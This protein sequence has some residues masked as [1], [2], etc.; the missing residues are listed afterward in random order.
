[1]LEKRWPTF[2]LLVLDW[3]II[4]DDTHVIYVKILKS[5][6]K[7]VMDGVGKKRMWCVFK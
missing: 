4:D 1:M 5:F 2:Y 3:L 6:Q 7:I